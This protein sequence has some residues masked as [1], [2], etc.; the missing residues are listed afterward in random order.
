MQGG[1]KVSRKVFLVLLALVLTLS[2]G[3]V[4]CGGTGEQQEEEEEEEEEE[5]LPQGEQE[6]EEE[7]YELTIDKTPGGMVTTPGEGTFA[8]DEGTE[9]ILVADAADFGGYRFIKWIGDAGLSAIPALRLSSL[10]TLRSL[11][12]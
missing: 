9:V 6:E 4:A 8:Y 12:I 10:T 7:V 3:L 11:W 5:E 1:E 2:V